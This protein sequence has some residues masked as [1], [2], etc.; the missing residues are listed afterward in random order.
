MK[1]YDKDEY[2]P[3]LR[4]ELEKDLGIIISKDLK[5]TDQSNKAASKANR[6]LGLTKRT[7]KSRDA[8][9]WKNLYTSY[10]RPHL[11]FAV[12]VWNPYAKSDIEKLEKIQHKAT[13]V[14]HTLKNLDHQ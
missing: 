11:E 14:S 5:F 13:K 4:T 8:S 3:F 7:F 12:P 2:L 10:M 9:T 6:M 1:S